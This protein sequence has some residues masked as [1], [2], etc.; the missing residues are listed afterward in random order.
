MGHRKW[1]M[2]NEEHI[3]GYLKYHMILTMN[4]WLMG[5]LFYYFIIAIDFFNLHACRCAWS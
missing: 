1:D 4:I 2:E 5:Y 3:N